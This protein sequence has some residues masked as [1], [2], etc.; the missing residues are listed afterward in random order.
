MF[1]WDETKRK[2]NLAKHSGDF[3]AVADMDW[4]N[5]LRLRDEREHYGESRYLALG[6]IGDRLYG[7][8]LRLAARSAV[9]SAY[10]KP[11]DVR[12]NSMKK[13]QKPL[14][15]KAGDV[16]ELTREYFRHMV[17]MRE[18]EPAFVAKWEAWQR[19]RGRPIGRHKTVVSMSLDKDLLAAL[20][21]SGSGWQTR[22]N[23]LLKAALGLAEAGK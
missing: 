23:D 21:K 4:A 10:A 11:I 16:R 13:K 5:A 20:R 15:N 14:T 19:K 22:V 8:V 9:S 3:A 2:D 17:P 12:R 7:C 6:Y 18:A 1:A